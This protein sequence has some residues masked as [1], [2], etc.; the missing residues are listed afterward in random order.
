M[1]Q[2][3][4]NDHVVVLRPSIWN[5]QGVTW[6]DVTIAI[7]TFRLFPAGFIA[8]TKGPVI[9]PKTDP[10]SVFGL[11]GLLNSH[12]AVY[13]TELL[14]PT[15]STKINDIFR[16][17]YSLRTVQSAGCNT[18]ELVE[19]SKSDWDSF[20]TSWDFQTLPVLQPKQRTLAQS[21]AAADAEVLARFQRMKQLEEENNRLFIEAYGLQ[22]ELSPEVPEDQITLARPD[23][24][25]DIKR[26][27]SY[28]I[29]CMMGRYS[30]NHE[31][32]HEIHESHERLPFLLFV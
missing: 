31:P 12:F 17:P 18:R 2:H 1:R 15:V 20:E 19:L 14:N 4:R 30:L 21:Q 11:L 10:D 7:P 5:S 25:E 3:Y 6:S 13:V 8:E 23:R 32:D 22:D 24:E 26:L 16:I 27:I 28:A 29:G 9:F